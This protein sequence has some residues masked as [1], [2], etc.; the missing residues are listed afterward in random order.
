MFLIIKLT[1][2]RHR[3]QK[4]LQRYY[5]FTKQTNF[6]V[7][8]FKISILQRIPNSHGKENL[9]SRFCVKQKIESEDLLSKHD[10]KPCLLEATRAK[11]GF[12]PRFFHGKTVILDA[13]KNEF[14]GKKL[15][16]QPQ[17][18]VVL[19]TDFSF[20]RY[21]SLLSLWLSVAFM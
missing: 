13:E 19:E 8:L 10:I 18:L 11:N 12:I 2:S 7:P 17:E 9:P 1:L 4:A 16:F 14:I 3:L 6:F 5:F 15:R 21:K 20:Y